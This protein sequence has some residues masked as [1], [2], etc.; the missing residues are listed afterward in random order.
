M[1]DPLETL[2]Q[3]HAGHPLKTP[4]VSGSLRM[5]E[6]SRSSEG[7]LAGCFW[8]SKDA[9]DAQ[10]WAS[11]HPTPTVSSLAPKSACKPLKL[12]VQHPRQQDI[13]GIPKFFGLSAL[14]V[15]GQDLRSE[16]LRIKTEWNEDVTLRPEQQ[17][18]VENTCKTLDKWGGA[19]FVADCG[20]GKSVIVARLIHRIGRRAMVLVPRLTLVHQM[21]QDLGGSSSDRR[22]LLSGA[23]VAV[24]QGSW[25]KCKDAV[26]HADIVVAS[27]DSVASFRFPQSFWE[28]FG[29]VMF[30]EAH[31]MAAKTLSAILPHV[32]SKRIVGLS[33]TPNRKD[34][35]EHVLFWLLGPTSFVYQR[36]PSV[37]GVKNT[38]QVKR[39]RGVKI[40][41]V[42]MYGG[43]LAFA[44]MLNSVAASEE[45]NDMIVKLVED[46]LPTRKKILV[47]TAFREHCDNLAEK[48]Q[49]LVPVQVL[50]GGKKRKRD[51]VP[52]SLVVATYGLLEEGFDDA[53][54]DTLVLCTPRSTVQQTIGRIERVKAGKLVP[55]VLDIV[56]H[57]SVFFAMWQKRKK[58]YG[59]RG[60]SVDDGSE[61]KAEPM[62]LGFVLDSDSE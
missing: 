41:D 39:L 17:K 24:L 43:K 7:V 13:V 35:L 52:T 14:G 53:D 32:P 44:A 56:D 5:H 51:D 45:R 34:G 11:L 49:S 15:P 40:D 9:L 6:S 1:E 60:F 19:F 38:V 54:L 47:I 59:S 37:T 8:V 21:V 20:F 50:H 18:G 58:F 48:L 33:A 42:F 3:T 31:H 2:L 62:D 36:L 28:T 10:T 57:N 4:F 16:G 30:D 46:L 23:T 25:E 22:P 26:E 29:L 61:P 27:L 12:V 55:L